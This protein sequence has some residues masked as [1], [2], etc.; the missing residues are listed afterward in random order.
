MLLHRDHFYFSITILEN[1]TLNH[2]LKNPTQFKFLDP[3]SLLKPRKSSHKVGSLVKWISFL[4]NISKAFHY[5]RIRSRPLLFKFR[6]E[7]Q[8]LD[9]FC[10]FSLKP[11]CANPIICDHINVN[12]NWADI[13]Y[14]AQVKLKYLWL[15]SN[16]IAL[17][18]PRPSNPISNT[19]GS[20]RI[21]TSNEIQ[22]D[23]WSRN[24]VESD[25]RSP[26]N[27]QWYSIIGTVKR[28]TIIGSDRTI[29]D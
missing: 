26:I 22:S 10:W 2:D 19:I 6:E 29:L 14:C 5:F 15:I 17:E 1:F 21:R 12:I 25:G 7:P 13:K 18:L 20:Y 27:L 11:N 16:H 3:H 8:C 4:E 23:S 24:D 28:F 9:N